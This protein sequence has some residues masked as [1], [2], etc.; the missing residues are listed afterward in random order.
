MANDLL[1]LR[2]QQRAARYKQQRVA[3]THNNSQFQAISDGLRRCGSDSCGGCV[4]EAGEGCG[5]G[6]RGGIRG[7]VRDIGVSRVSGYRSGCGG[8][9]DQSI[10]SRGLASNDGSRRHG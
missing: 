7:A 8:E 1:H 10:R 5:V 3:G 4:S 9:T 2:R 6:E